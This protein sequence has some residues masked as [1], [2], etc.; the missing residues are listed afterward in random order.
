[1]WPAAGEQ[2]CWNY[3]IIR[4]LDRV[5]KREQREAK[6]MVQV[7]V[8]APSRAAGAAHKAFGD[9]YGEDYARG[10]ENL[11]DKEGLLQFSGLAPDPPPHDERG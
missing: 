1:M 4:V 5:A 8:Y 3:K 6:Q 9:R 10:V 2:L 7:I 11:V